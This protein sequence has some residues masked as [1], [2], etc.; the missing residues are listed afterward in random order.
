VSFREI[1][2]GFADSQSDFF[3]YRAIAASAKAV[4]YKIT[5]EQYRAGQNMQEW[6]SAVLKH[7]MVQ[8]WLDLL[9]YHRVKMWQ[10]YNQDFAKDVGELRQM[11]G[12]VLDTQIKAKLQT[13]GN[14]VDAKILLWEQQ[15]TEQQSLTITSTL[16]DTDEERPEYEE[17]WRQRKKIWQD[18]KLEIVAY[19][20]RNK[21]RLL[22]ENGYNEILSPDAISREVATIYREV[23]DIVVEPPQT[24]T[25]ERV[26]ALGELFISAADFRKISQSNDA[27]IKKAAEEKVKMLLKIK[28]FIHLWSY[29]YKYHYGGCWS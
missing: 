15:I 25:V 16:S 26:A 19:H 8:A 28:S 14:E 13:L 29:H 2:L 20:E 24:W 21:T 6:R 23:T 17:K 4:L 12:K 18:I 3:R 5:S 10:K 22:G 27:Q 11:D 9:K 7:P 1:S